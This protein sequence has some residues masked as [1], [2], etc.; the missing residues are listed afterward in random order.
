LSRSALAFLWVALLTACSQ[1]TEELPTAAV[2]LEQTEPEQIYEV[3]CAGCHDQGQGKAAPL[4]T[5]ARKNPASVAFAMLNGTM[6]NQAKGLEIAQVYA[7]TEWIAGAQV[8]YKPLPQALCE[9]PTL[10]LDTV[11]VDRWGF[12]AQ[13]TAAVGRDISAIDSANVA[14][15]ILRWAFEL[16]GVS[17]AR[18]QPVIV[19][20]TLFVAAASGHVFAL[21]RE[22][23]CIKWHTATPAPLR[24]AL[25]F[26][27]VGPTARALLFVGDVESHTSALDAYTGELLWRQDTAVAEFSIQTG[28]VTLQ[29]DALF[30]PV[31]LVEVV[32]AQDPEFECCRA[33][34]AVHRLDALTGAIQWT[35]HM[36]PPAQPRGKTKAGTPMWGPSGVP[37]WSTPTV[38]VE[39][40]LVYIGTGQNASAPGTALSDSVV[41]L[42]I[43]T[44]NVAWHFQAT[45]GDTYNGACSAFPKGDSCPK[46]QGPDFDFGASIIRA[47]HSD[48]SEL[49]LAGQKSGD[50]YALDPDA[51]GR[52][53]WRSRVGSGSALG[54][55]HWGMAVADGKVF[56]AA[57]DPPFPGY[58]AEPGLYAL[59]MDSGNL[60]WE[61]RVERGCEMAMNPYFQREELY[62][63]CSFY[64]AFSAALSVANDVVF[65]PAL[66]GRLRAFDTGDG[67]LL[68]TYETA[69][70]FT[71]AAGGLAHGGSI[72]SAG[73]QFAGDMAYLQSGY[74]LFGQLPGNVLL[75]FGLP[76]AST[77]DDNRESASPTPEPAGS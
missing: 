7:L 46:W 21:D 57:N 53:I 12:D 48:G 64:Y 27:R 31:S 70:E 13:K 41:A 60:L 52:V 4:A 15:L 66:D 72:D 71:T 28:A 17:E 18:S 10:A 3:R 14:E 73:V 55:V 75:A 16:P 50:V 69:R 59:D 35:T 58:S 29:G 33:H 8:D 23:G 6:R 68:W 19:G 5:L 54:G 67:T 47:R 40:G 2:N 26:G 36:T 56:A 49:L 44:G 22:L 45:A 62:P 38:D 63:D 51:E 11:F 77:I 34:G 42:D 9:H 74:G 25:T 20:D 32:L 37:V 61:Y 65:A 39:R 1:P 76:S 43:D 24:T 30:V